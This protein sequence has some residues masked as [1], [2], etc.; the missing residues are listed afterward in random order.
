M[1]AWQSR[2]IE[3]K[4]DLDAKIDSLEL[5]LGMMN[6]PPM[7]LAAIGLLMQQRDAMR[8]YSEILGQRIDLFGLPHPQQRFG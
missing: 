4:K 1:E 2:V 8:L 6:R 5:F 3:E 7:S